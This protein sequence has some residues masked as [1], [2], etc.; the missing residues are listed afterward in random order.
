[1]KGTVYWMAPEVLLS[2]GKGYDV[3]VDIWSIGC[4]AVEMWSGRRPWAD[5][6]M[7]QVMMKVRLP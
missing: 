1:M 6:Q 3:S 2:D 7:V 4:L 5:F